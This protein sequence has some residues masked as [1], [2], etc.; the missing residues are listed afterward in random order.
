[1]GY[2]DGGV[3]LL[4]PYHAARAGFL[5]KTLYDY[6]KSEVTTSLEEAETFSASDRVKLSYHVDGF[7]QFSGEDRGRIVSGRD[8]VTGEPKGLGIVANPMNRPVQT[9]PAFGVMLWGLEDFDLSRTKPRGDA[10]AFGPDDFVYDHCDESSWGSYGIE[11]FVFGMFFQPHVRQTAQRSYELPLWHNQFYG[12]G[13]MFNFKVVRLGRQPF[14]L[15]AA[16]F[17]RPPV[18]FPSPSG[19]TMASPGGLAA[20]PI[21]PQL[22]AFYPADGGPEATRSLDFEAW[23]EAQATGAVHTQFTRDY[24]TLIERAEAE[25]ATNAAAEVPEL[26]LLRDG[27]GLLAEAL[28]GQALQPQDLTSVAGQRRIAVLT[29]ALLSLRTV[30]M[31]AMLIAAGYLPEATLALERLQSARRLAITIDE[32]EDGTAATQYLDGGGLTDIDPSY[33]GTELMSLVPMVDQI[34]DISARAGTT[35]PGGGLAFVG[36]R[37]PEKA[38][39]IAVAAAA[40]TGDIANIA[41]ATLYGDTSAESP[42]ARLAR[43]RGKVGALMKADPAGA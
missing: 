7:V 26:R 16:C 20:G 1:M 12:K 22:H 23:K 6:S 19:W 39:R 14:F 37:D 13:R 15:G 5:T 35:A 43:F 25:F 30:R 10:I 11:F 2:G 34:P 18:D 42:A 4:S 38:K 9:G 24:G 33:T 27:A 41:C 21:K 31:C 8:P 17:R 28:E 3:S 40:M 29:L 32:S 36:P